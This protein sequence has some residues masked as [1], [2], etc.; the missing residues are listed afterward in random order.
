MWFHISDL[1]FRD[2]CRTFFL[3]SKDNQYMNSKFFPVV[4]ALRAWSK[5]IMGKL[6]FHYLDN[7][8][9]RSTFI[10]AGA[11]TSLGT[12]LVTDYVDFECNRR[13][14]S[15]FARVASRSNPADQPSRLNFAPIWLRD[16]ERFELVLP[17]FSMVRESCKPQ[18][19]VG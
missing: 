7:D 4:V 6:V 12:T 10:R 18:Q 9:A 2:P 11:S 8:A 19:P 14:S 3:K 16:T 13:F 1:T 5:F 15:W 17:I